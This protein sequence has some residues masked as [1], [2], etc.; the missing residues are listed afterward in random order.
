VFEFKM[1]RSPR[2]G[3]VSPSLKALLELIAQLDAIA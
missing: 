3:L 1:V 2:W